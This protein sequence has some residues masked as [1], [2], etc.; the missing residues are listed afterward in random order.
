[1]GGLGQMVEQNNHFG[2]YAPEKMPHAIT[3]Y[4]NEPKR[5]YGLL[6]RH[7]TDREFINADHSIADMAVYPRIVPYERQQQDLADFPNLE[8]GFETVQRRPAVEHAYDI[9]RRINETPVVTEQSRGL[10]FGHRR[11]V[12]R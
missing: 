2:R 1:M 10:L 8:R 5:L 7:L 11:H 4:V 6:D 3:R 12:A 9:A